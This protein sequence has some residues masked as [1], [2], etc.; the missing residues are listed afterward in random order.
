LKERILKKKQDL[1]DEAKNKEKKE[2]EA[3]KIEA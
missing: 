3:K 2:K 1:A